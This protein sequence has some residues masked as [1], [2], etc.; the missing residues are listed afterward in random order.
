MKTHSTLVAP[1][2]VRMERLLPGPVERVWSYIFDGE[3]RA[4]WFC[5]G[6]TEL[7][8]GGR[9]DM[10]FDNNSLSADKNPPPHHKDGNTASFTGQITRLEP[11]RL[12]AH[13]WPWASGDTEVTYELTPQGDQVLLTIV[14]QLKGERPTLL[15]GMSGWDVH[16]GVLEDLLRGQAPR[17]FWQEHTRLVAQYG[18]AVPA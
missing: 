3:K 9:I 14:H 15:N 17:M 13:T 16:S 18:D 6:A 4:K 7:R 10:K 8:V 5:G 1:G 12:L 2:T 11:M